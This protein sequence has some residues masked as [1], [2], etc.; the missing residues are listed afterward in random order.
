MPKSKRPREREEVWEELDGPADEPP[1]RQFGR[2]RPPRVTVDVL[3]HDEAIIVVAK[4]PGLPIDPDERPVEEGHALLIAAERLKIPTRGLRLIDPVEAEVSGV[5]VVARTAD[6]ASILQQQ[7]RQSRFTHVTLAL[8]R[9]APDERTGRIDL[10]IGSD[11]KFPDQVRVGGS[12][13]KPAVTEWTLRDRF[14][15]F[16]LLE[17]RT[18]HERRH[19]LRIHLQAMGMPLAVD[20]LYG[21]NRELLLSTFKPDFHASR[22]H[23]ERPLMRRLSLHV[24]RLQFAHPFTQAALEFTAPPPRDLKA[25]LTQLDRHGRIGLPQT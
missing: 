11:R 24:E 12:A 4:P 21:G 9:A 13:A 17:C 2:K 10:E 5:V 25:A 20:P 15:G 7:Q 1:R 19:Q 14:V 3:H 16:A 6:A 18:H 23:D 22:R 8:V